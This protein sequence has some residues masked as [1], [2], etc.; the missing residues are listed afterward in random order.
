M[1]KLRAKP[2]SVAVPQRRLRQEADPPIVVVGHLPEVRGNLA[3]IRPIRRTRPLLGERTH[4]RMID[5][6][7][8]DGRMNQRGG[9]HAPN[10]RKAVEA[11]KRMRVNG[12][13]DVAPTECRRRE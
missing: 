12:E 13:T 5:H 9:Q 6:G 2:Q 8:L 3:A 10:R 7:A 1:E 11:G 4:I